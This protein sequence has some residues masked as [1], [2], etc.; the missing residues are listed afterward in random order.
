MVVDA[1]GLIE[2]EEWWWA[3]YNSWEKFRQC[4]GVGISVADLIRRKA[5]TEKLK[6]RFEA[7]ATTVWGGKESLREALGEELMLKKAGRSCLEKMKK[8]SS[9]VRDVGLARRIYCWRSVIRGLVCREAGSVKCCSRGISKEHW[10]E[11]DKG[12]LE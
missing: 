10:I 1:W 11:L 2:R 4:C 12:C 5:I 3:E 6:R 7:N 9:V 8:L